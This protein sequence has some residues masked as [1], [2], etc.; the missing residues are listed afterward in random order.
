MEKS[1]GKT[2]NSFYA[3]KER[4]EEETHEA[5]LPWQNVLNYI[6]YRNTLKLKNLTYLVYVK[7]YW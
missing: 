3:V 1:I 5:R 7:D 2:K 4:Q 6:S